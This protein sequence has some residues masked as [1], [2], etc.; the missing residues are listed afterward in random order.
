[1]CCG[2]R[3]ACFIAAPS[4]QLLQHQSGLGDC[5]ELSEVSLSVE[6]TEQQV[7]LMSAL[8]IKC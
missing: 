4:C 2:D 6:T 5:S 1:M 3:E 8:E 7:R